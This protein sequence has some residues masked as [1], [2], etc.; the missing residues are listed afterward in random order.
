MTILQFSRLNLGTRLILMHRTTIDAWF[1]SA[2]VKVSAD[3]V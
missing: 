1:D 3:D 2:E